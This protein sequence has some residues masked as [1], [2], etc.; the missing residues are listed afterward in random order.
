MP[1]YIVLLRGVNVGKAKRV[2][3]VKFQALLQSLGYS[4]V[5][6]LLNSG[7]A[8]FSAPKAASARY[9]EAIVQAIAAEFNFDV[10]VVV[11][12]AVEFT[13]I[14]DENTL[15]TAE[16]DHSRLLVVFAQASSTL[17]GLAGI[18][19]LVVPP[20]QLL[21]GKHAAFLHCARGILQS[22]AGEAIL[23]K[24]GRATT[25]RNWA[26]VLKLQALSAK[27]DP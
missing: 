21:I 24:V 8:V 26:T 15:V 10:P 17:S 11:K 25:T 7:N 27:C 1:R 6:T 2:P 14:I 5:C 19:D 22:A 20:E 13:K 3:M 23:S 9:A 16:V 18:A 12:S 4:S